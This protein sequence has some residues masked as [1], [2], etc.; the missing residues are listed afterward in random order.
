MDK[1]K[2]VEPEVFISYS[3]DNEEIKSWVLQL[4]TRLRN[5]GVNAIL[6]VWQLRLGSDLASFM[7]RGLSKSHRV[8]CVCSEGYVKK[9][10][11]GKGGAGYEKQIVTAELVK[12]QN[13][14]WVIPLIRNNP[15][16]KKTPTFLAGRMYISF[17]DDRM[18]E[19]NYEKLLRDLL[20]E[21]V[22]PIPPIGKNP[23]QNIREFAQQSYIPS[24]EKYLSPSTKGIVTFDYSNNDGI[25]TIG[26]GSL[27]F[28]CHFSKGSNTGINIYND[29]PSVKAV[30]LVK[31]KVDIFDINDARIYDFSSRS[32]KVGINQF[33]I[34][35]NNNG[36]YAALKVLSIKDDRFMGHDDEVSFEY[37]IQTNGSPD[38]SS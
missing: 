8:I 11:E 29:Q 33:A 12:D 14:N 20:E 6:D 1:E 2:I 3:H 36:F 35:Q 7:E 17:E 22:L 37:F 27:M 25:Y 28:E 34:Y 18:Y 38:F 32:R 16:E 21:P 19:T 23:F 30:A 9:A 5:N 31:D 26:Q 10:N 24:N 13:T 15:S 4:A